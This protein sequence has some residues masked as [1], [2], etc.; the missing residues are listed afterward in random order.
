MCFQY[1]QVLGRIFSESCFLWFSSGPW[2]KRRVV[3]V[4]SS[5]LPEL[6][7]GGTDS[8]E[9]TP[10][11]KGYWG[12]WKEAEGFVLHLKLGRQEI[13]GLFQSREEAEAYQ[14]SMLKKHL[15]WP[16]APLTE[17]VE[18]SELFDHAEEFEEMKEYVF[19]DTAPGPSILRPGF[20]QPDQLEQFDEE[21]FLLRLPVLNEEELPPVKE[22][23]E[24]L[25]ANR[26]DKITCETLR[27]RAAHTMPRPLHQEL[28]FL[29]ME[30][31]N[32]LHVVEDILGPRYV[33]WSAHLF[34]KLPGDP[35]VQPFH[36]DAGFWPLSQ[37]RALTVWVALDDV[38]E[39]NA[40]LVYI[41]GSHRC[42]RL[43]WRRTAASHF[44]LPQE[45]PDADCIG[46][47]VVAT[48]RAGEASVHSDLT[49]H[50]SPA[51]S[52]SRRRAGIA[53]RFVQADARCLGPMLNGYEMNNGCILP[54]GRPLS[55]A[56][57]WKAARRK[58]PKPGAAP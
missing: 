43:G 2:L 23:F 36:Q 37:S 20:L 24:R 50:H 3:E 51:N 38:D 4:R 14:A 57:H 32:I 34:C 16:R 22:A 19:R 25:L 13:N 46:E 42:G 18:R 47:P 1:F 44:L 58:R 11:L 48:L 12:I 45:I 8:V 5:E 7:K 52:S 17:K 10:K 21:G 53:L 28:V 6:L 33:C 55:G 30:N 39:G 35:T 41:R 26:V 15:D 49:M 31:E 56:E 54:R 27:F 9:R 29:L 40:G